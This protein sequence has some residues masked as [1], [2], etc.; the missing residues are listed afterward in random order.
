MTDPTDTD[1]KIIDSKLLTFVD[2]RDL[3]GKDQEQEQQR[4]CDKEMSCTYI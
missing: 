3:W 2:Q 4:T 1:S